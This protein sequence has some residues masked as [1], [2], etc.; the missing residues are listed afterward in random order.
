MPQPGRQCGRAKSLGWQGWPLRGFGLFGASRL[1]CRRCRRSA[2][3][4]RGVEG[5]PAGFANRRRRCYRRRRQ[6]RR[7]QWFGICQ[8]DGAALP[9]PAPIA[10]LV[11]VDLIKRHWQGRRCAAATLPQQSRGSKSAAATAGPAVWIALCRRRH[12]ACRRQRGGRM[13]NP[14]QPRAEMGQWLCRC[15]R[16]LQSRTVGTCGRDLLHHRRER[17]KRRKRNA[18]ID[19]A[20][21]INAA[22]VMQ[23]RRRRRERW[24]PQRK[25]NGRCDCC[26]TSPRRTPVS[27]GAGDQRRCQRLKQR[28]RKRQPTGRG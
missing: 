12:A 24:W 7:L 15:E 23:R 25:G 5:R 1:R 14:A 20:L 10:M 17:Q 28:R 19:A 22:I 18:V 6:W 4:R 2:W 13:R 16:A 3:L 8:A 9:P 11:R 21:V 26:F 27:P